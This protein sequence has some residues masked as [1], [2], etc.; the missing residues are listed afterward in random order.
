VRGPLAQEQ[1]QRRLREALDAREDVPAP[2]V[3]APGARAASHPTT[4]KTHM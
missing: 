2:A 3:V 1:Q 4:C